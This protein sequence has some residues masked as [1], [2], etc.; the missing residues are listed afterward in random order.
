MNNEQMNEKLAG[1]IGWFLSDDPEWKRWMS[2]PLN[3]GY[4]DMMFSADPKDE[5]YFS[6]TTDHNHMDMVLEKMV[7]DGYDYN[8][9]CTQGNY[10]VEFWWLTDN[11][12][13]EGEHL[14]P[15]IAQAVLEAIGGEE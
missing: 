7:E 1:V 12:I 11:F 2:D 10:A 14:L 15:T 4:P 9:D 8:T 5:R 6:P 13:A 3:T